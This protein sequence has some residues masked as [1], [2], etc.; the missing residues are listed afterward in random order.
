VNASKVHWTPSTFESIVTNAAQHGGGWI[1][2]LI[3]D[4]CPGY[5]KYGITGPQLQQVLSW[6]HDRTGPGLAVKT[7]HQ[8]IG[9]RV[10]AAVAGPVPPAIRG[11]GIANPN[12]ADPGQGYPACFQP[13]DYGVN[14]VAFGYQP[15]GGPGG[16]A[17]ETVRMTRAQSG[18]A[19]LLQETDLGE[20][21]P[22]V[23][24]GHGY[25]LG[26]WYKSSLPTQL[27][28]YYRDQIGNWH[29]WRSS[30][31]FA[32]AATWQHASW[33]TPGAPAGATAI[34]FGLAVG[35]VGQITTTSYSLAAAPPDLARPITFI[36]V[37]LAL[38]VPFISWKLW[39]PRL[40][41]GRRRSGRHGPSDLAAAGAMAGRQWMAAPPPHQLVI[42]LDTDEQ[43]G[44]E[45]VTPPG[46][47]ASDS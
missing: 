20:C 47:D 26:A 31:R 15:T 32:A 23:S 41:R 33:T 34:S 27:D 29:Y 37:A 22:P 35:G 16:A 1:V 39:G 21:A 8:V 3:H 28:V 17:T 18:D 30:P 5:C 45:P 42:G 38:T 44:A 11:T 19:K 12:L 6:L 36:A 46:A 25:V 13:A 9:G 4:I 7:V 43:P 10:K 14:T 24:G 2:F 40:A